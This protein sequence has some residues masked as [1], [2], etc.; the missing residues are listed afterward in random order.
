MIRVI[1]DSTSSISQDEAKQLGIDIVPLYVL[2]ND[3]MYKDR[4]DFTDDEFYKLLKE[5][6]PS[7]S[8]PSP[9]DFL[10]VFNKYPE[11]EIICITLSE[12]LSGTYQSAVVA[13]TMSDNKNIRVINSAS[14][15]L[16]MKILVLKALEMIEDGIAFHDIADEIENLKTKIVMMGMCDTMENLKRGGRISNIKF[17]A[18]SILNIKPLLILEDGLLQA[19]KKKVR[20]KQNAINVMIKSLSELKWDKKSNIFIG[21]TNNMEN[22]ELL[23]KRLIEYDINEI[24]DDLVELGSVIATHTGE[25]AFIIA[26]ISED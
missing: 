20:G 10:E 21:Y 3:K 19:Y 17:L 16:A 7:T 1:T 8:Q 26:Y 22:A 6:Q 12:R 25:N 2:L 18:G 13:K 24:D 11:D 15:S 23:K 5:N 4:L 9:Q 14:A